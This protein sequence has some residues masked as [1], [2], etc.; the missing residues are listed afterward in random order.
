MN[1]GQ[2]EQQ[3]CLSAQTI[4]YGKEVNLVVS[5]LWTNGCWAYESR[6]MRESCIL[7]N[8]RNVSFSICDS[9]LLLIFYEDR[10]RVSIDV[11]SI[12]ETYFSEIDDKFTGLESLRDVLA[13]LVCAC[14]GDEIPDR[15]ILDGVAGEAGPEH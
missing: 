5:E 4:R 10:E 6:D 7:Q 12:V 8:A 14:R 1:L 15:P 11:K 13:R 2:A 9:R 3:A